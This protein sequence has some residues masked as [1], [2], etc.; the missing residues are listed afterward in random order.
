MSNP[1]NKY[2]RQPA[3]H[4]ELPSKGRWWRPGSLN[5]GPTGLVPICPMTARDEILLKTP[6]ALMNGLAMVEIFQSCSPAIKDGWSC[7]KVDVDA[8]LIGI[9]IASYGQN[10]D[11]DSVCPHCKNTNRFAFDLTKRLEQIKCPNFDRPLTYKD[12]VIKFKPNVYFN[13]NRENSTSFHEEKLRQVV[14]RSDLSDEEKIQQMTEYAKK[15]LDA[16][17]LSLTTQ[18]EFI[19]LEDG[20]K[21]NE[22]EFIKEF[23]DNID[24]DSIR[25]ITDYISSIYKEV[26]IPP[27]EF[28]CQECTGEYKSDFEFDY[29]NFFVRGF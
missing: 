26:E 16:S 20:I 12:I 18:T 3:I 22:H 9:R 17:L 5:M 11:I 4:L 10:L 24:G 2:F 19:Q 23:Y 1:L 15:M 27:L 8:L 13:T 25:Y 29:S 14:E 7:P 21:V 28:K 6:D